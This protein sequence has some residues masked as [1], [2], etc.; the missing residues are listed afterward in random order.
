MIW[1][2]LTLKRRKPIKPNQPKNQFLKTFQTARHFQTEKI[3]QVA[4]T[5]IPKNLSNRETLK[6]QPELSKVKNCQTPKMFQ[7]ATNIGHNVGSYTQAGGFP[8]NCPR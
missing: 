8:I 2:K 1:S 4:R 6:N 5:K 7:V 3:Y